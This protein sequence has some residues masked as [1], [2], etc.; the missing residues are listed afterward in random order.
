[1]AG[2]M[3]TGR[4]VE[5]SVGEVGSRAL[6]SERGVA[7]VGP[8]GLDAA[9]HLRAIGCDQTTLAASSS[10]DGVYSIHNIRRV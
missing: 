4:A 9:Q 7:E 3:C 6:G 8:A 5:V 2:I 1:M 10:V